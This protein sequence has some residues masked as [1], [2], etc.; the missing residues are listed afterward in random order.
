MANTGR[1]RLSSGA[2]AVRLF[3]NASINRVRLPSVDLP[4]SGRGGGVGVRAKVGLNDCPPASP[5]AEDAVTAD[6]AVT[7][8]TS[9]QQ[10]SE[11]L[12]AERTVCPA[13]DTEL[14]AGQS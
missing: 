2:G 3:L 6:R 13:S 4:F 12:T 9:S 7:T 8:G 10:I 5:V 14:K 1:V 11:R